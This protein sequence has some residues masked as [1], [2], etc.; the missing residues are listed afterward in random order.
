M[1]LPHLVFHGQALQPTM[2]V[3]SFTTLGPALKHFTYQKVFRVILLFARL[4][5]TR[6]E[7][8][9]AGLKGEPGIKR[10]LDHC[11]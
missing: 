9:D 11:K 1:I 3:R 10:I 4:E 6:V 2:N 5:A 7:H 8:T